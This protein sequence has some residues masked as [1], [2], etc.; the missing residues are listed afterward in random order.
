MKEGKMMGKVVGGPT[1]RRNSM[2]KDTRV[3]ELKEKRVLDTILSFL[4][5]L[6]VGI[7]NQ[8]RN[9]VKPF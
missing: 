3:K 2:C 4:W 6:K 5:K 8:S 7:D 9:T 1:R